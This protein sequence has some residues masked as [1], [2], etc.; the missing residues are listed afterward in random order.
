MSNWE[1]IDTQSSAS[2]FTLQLHFT[3]EDDAPE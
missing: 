1:L 2:G 3:P